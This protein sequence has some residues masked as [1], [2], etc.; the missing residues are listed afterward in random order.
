MNHIEAMKTALEALLRNRFSRV[1]GILRT[2]IEAA[3]KQE[4]VA[5]VW[6]E[7]Y[8]AGVND[9][10]MSEANIGIAGFGA[11]VEP[12]RNNPYRTAPL[13]APVQKPVCRI[14]TGTG[15]M[16]SGGTQPWGEAINIPCECTTPPAAP[17]QEPVG[18]M[19]MN[20]APKNGTR[21][22]CKNE[23]EF[24]DI[25]EWTP[26]D[27]GGRFTSSDDRTFG[28]GPTYIGWQPLPPASTPP[29][30]SVKAQLNPY[31][32]ADA[33]VYGPEYQ[34]QQPAPC[35]KAEDGVC[36][37]LDCGCEASVQKPVVASIN[38]YELIRSAFNAGIKNDFETLGTLEKQA[39]QALAAPVQ[40]PK[41]DL[42]FS[43]VAMQEREAQR[44]ERIVGTLEQIKREQLTSPVTPPA[45]PMQIGT[46]GHIGNGKAT[47]TASI[48]STL[49]T[50]PP[51]VTT[52]L[53]AQPAPV[54]D[55]VGEWVDG[56]GD[57]KRIAWK[58]GYVAN[59]SVGDKLYTTPPAAQ[60]QWVYLTEL[61]KAEL[62]NRDTPI[63]FSYADAI[64]AKL[65]EKNS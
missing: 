32:A 6:D 48:L 1:E 17:V 51:N 47:L 8:R 57:P 64:E 37:N 33:G 3:E 9:E 20:T 28:H 61:E 60:R 40:E 7:G 24:V 35:N 21:I 34:N 56:R 5:Q 58:P 27:A 26:C 10:R 41:K 14:C 36:E 43:T 53:A 55:P 13:T 19:P 31:R 54:Q 63:A 38:L 16:D 52:P 39:E 30:A 4:P 44:I 65:K 22:L 50:A 62:W 45:A 18:W 46:I 2:A 23:E 12:A 11:K 25:C 15:E 49:Y 42:M 59:A 29:A